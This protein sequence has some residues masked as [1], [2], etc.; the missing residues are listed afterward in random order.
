VPFSTVATTTCAFATNPA[1]HRPPGQQ[2]P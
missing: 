1:Q 2:C